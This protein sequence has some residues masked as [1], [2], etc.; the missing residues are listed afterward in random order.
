MKRPVHESA[1]D[2]LKA[3]LVLAREHGFVRAVDVAERLGV[4]KASVSKALS[5]LERAGCIDIVCHDVRLTS[6]GRA[7]AE[8][9]LER[10]EFFW[11]LLV[12]AGV[13]ERTADE[14]ACRM[15][16]CLSEDSFRKL[17]AHMR[18]LPLAG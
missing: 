17:A 6:E 13:N 12:S 16:H 7:V 14:E 9:I 2:Y 3:V 11:S 18:A 4:S 8:R 1:E 5:K 10:H 15:E